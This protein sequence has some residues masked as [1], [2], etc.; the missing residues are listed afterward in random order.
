M[1]NDLLELI[2]LT[3]FIFLFCGLTVLLVLKTRTYVLVSNTSTYKDLEKIR[4]YF[5]LIGLAVL[6]GFLHSSSSAVPEK[7][8][9][10]SCVISCFFLVTW[11]NFSRAKE[12][13]FRN[14]KN[15]FKIGL[16]TSVVALPWKVLVVLL[17]QLCTLV[18]L[19]VE[20]FSN[21]H[22]EILMKNKL[23]SLNFILYVTCVVIL[24]PIIE[25]LLFRGIFQNYLTRVFSPLFAILVTSI[26]FA[27]YH[28]DQNQSI[29]SLSLAASSF[30]FSIIG[31]YVYDKTGNLLA[32]SFYHSISNLLPVLVIQIDAL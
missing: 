21:P 17:V 24:G 13:I 29:A 6:Q 9:F 25:E 27:Y 26:I 12:S 14:T 23:L 3:F 16:L 31:G 19:S 32:C 10:I 22:A 1:E 7:S 30:T 18:F 5:P 4:W 15:A 20:P 2:A 8:L 28:T 11:L